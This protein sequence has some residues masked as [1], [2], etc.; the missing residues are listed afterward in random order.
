M[1]LPS[2]PQTLLRGSALFL[3]FDG[4]LVPIAERPDAITVPPALPSLL[5][6]LQK[7]L[8][9]RLVLISGRGA[10]DVRRWL[11][12]LD[13]R[14]L[15]SHGLEQEGAAIARSAAFDE[16]RPHLKALQ[17]QHEGVVIEEKPMGA[18]IHFREAP[19]AEEACRTVA[20]HVA[21]SAGMQVLAGKMVFEI[22]PAVG[23]KGTALAALMK[24]PPLAGFRPLFIGDDLTD[25]YGFAAA[26]DLDGA[27]I[28]VGP[29]RDTAA[30]YRLE[31]VA[32]V[33]RWL[34]DACE[35]LA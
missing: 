2:P 3:D 23:N 6:R 17:T 35:Y 30:T 33:H 18:A 14:I 11:G 29:E 22:K 16:S 12:A 8:E 26:R 13:I 21:S 24:E 10:A 20:T 32:D 1:S 9:G 28:L 27:G 31:D 5:G 25:E 19:D 34:G 15:G 4:T 7:R